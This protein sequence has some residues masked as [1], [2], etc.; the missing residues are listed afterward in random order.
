MAHLRSGWHRG[1][2]GAQMSLCQFRF[3]KCLILLDF[4]S[5]ARV[6]QVAQAV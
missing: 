3:C 2:T 6:A 4:L 5:L 1:G